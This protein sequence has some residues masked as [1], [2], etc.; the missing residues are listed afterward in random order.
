MQVN[1]DTGLTFVYRDDQDQINARISLV[2]NLTVEGASI[3]VHE[4]DGLVLGLGAVKGQ[5]LIDQITLS[6][7]NITNP[8]RSQLAPLGE[9][10]M[11]VNIAPTSYLHIQVN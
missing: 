11:N 7:N 6:P 1:K 10:T 2:E 4:A 8:Q 3:N 5:V 9:L